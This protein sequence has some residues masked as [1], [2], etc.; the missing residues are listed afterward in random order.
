M[1][2]AL[3]KT[4]IAFAAIVLLLS[5][6]AWISGQWR[7]T[8]FGWA[9][10]RNHDAGVWHACGLDS[11][12]SILYFYYLRCQSPVLVL[13]P[14]SIGSDTVEPIA[15]GHSQFV[16]V[17]GSTRPNHHVFGYW[18]IPTSE[19]PIDGIFVAVPVWG[20]AIVSGLVVIPPVLRAWRRRRCARSRRCQGLCVHCGYDLRAS[21]ERCPECGAVTPEGHR[22][23][24]NP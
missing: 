17:W 20:L 1:L 24:S 14:R 19:V 9:G 10:W 4:L 8:V 7:R 2:I 16:R 23:K 21:A 5:L 12:Q 15:R 3:R 22:A 6:F 13:D 11:N 18:R